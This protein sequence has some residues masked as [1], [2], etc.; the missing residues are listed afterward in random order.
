MK[1]VGD[2]MDKFK[3]YKNEEQKYKKIINNIYI[4]IKQLDFKIEDLKK[5]KQ[6]TD[7]IIKKFK[8]NCYNYNLV[9]IM[10]ETRNELY[11]N[12]FKIVKKGAELQ[13]N[14]DI[15]VKI[16]RINCINE[17]LET[18]LIQ[19]KEINNQNVSEVERLQLN[20]I[21]KGIYDKFMITKSEI[22]RAR[23]K[24]SFD[25]IQNRGII[26]KAIDKFF[27]TEEDTDR[28]K[29]NLFFAIHEIDNMRAQIINNEEPKKDYK[30]IEI[31]AEIQLFIRENENEKEYI[32]K[33][34]IIKELKEKIIETFSIEKSKLKFEI[35]K[36]ET[37][38]L[39]VKVNKKMNKAL[40]E[41]QQ[42]IAF[43]TKNGYS[44]HASEIKFESN[45]EKVINKLD[46]ISNNLKSKSY[47]L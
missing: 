16:K 6:K 45:L 12:F 5:S 43:L 4:L 29:E 3:Y 36:L 2:T 40:R 31:M 23:I 14:P 7:N 28:K 37:T 15:D 21:K 19:L 13:S 33:L 30:I 42:I 17:L 44:Q 35:K 20:A 39:P 1:K 27:Q 34:E 22:D 18:T 46:I 24:K 11:Y 25:K 8:I 41:K 38:K 26:S 32:E 47:N 9:P 10:I